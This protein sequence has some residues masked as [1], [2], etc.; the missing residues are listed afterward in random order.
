MTEQVHQSQRIRERIAGASVADA[1]TGDIDMTGLN[2]VRYH[3]QEAEH[4][5][6]YL[7]GGA[8]AIDAAETNLHERAAL[9][10]EEAAALV[11]DSIA[12]ARAAL[13]AAEG[14]SE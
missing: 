2:L 8:Q 10:P 14:V 7:A 5:A 12:N 4:A 6:E 3:L 13:D 11:R 1:S 9:T